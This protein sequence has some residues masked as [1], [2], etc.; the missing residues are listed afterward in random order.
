MQWTDFLHAGSNSGKVKVVSMIGCS[1]LIHETPKSVVSASLTFK[2][3][4]TAVVL[5]GPLAVARRVQ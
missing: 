1:H 3:Q 4:P 5:V 2:C